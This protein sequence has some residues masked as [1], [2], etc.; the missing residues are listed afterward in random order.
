MTNGGRNMNV[1]DIIIAREKMKESSIQRRWTI[2]KLLV[3][4][5]ITKYI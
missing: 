1:D 2:P 4:W 5:L 3:Y